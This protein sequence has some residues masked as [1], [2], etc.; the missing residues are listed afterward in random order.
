MSKLWLMGVIL[1]SACATPSP[2]V[3]WER[4]IDWAKKDTGAPD[5]PVDYIG[6][7]GG[8]ECLVIGIGGG[9]GAGNRKCLMNLA[10]SEAFRGKCDVAYDMALTAQCHNGKSKR[11]L[12]RVS[13]EA[14]CNYLKK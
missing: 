14:V 1:L 12:Q 6:Y 5:C 4:H 3:N 9:T 13:Q 8:R 7:D 2:P 10:R 11:E